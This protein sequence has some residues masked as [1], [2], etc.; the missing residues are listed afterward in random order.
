MVRRANLLGRGAGRGRRTAVVGRMDRAPLPLARGRIPMPKAERALLGY[1]AAGQPDL[2]IGRSM[3][4]PRPLGSVMN[5]AKFGGPIVRQVRSGGRHGHRRQPGRQQDHPGLQSAM[6]DMD[7]TMIGQECIDELADYVGL[8]PHIAAITERAMRGEIAFEPALR[9][10][11]ALLK[12]L[13]PALIERNHQEPHHADA[14]RPRPWSPPCAS[15]APGPAWCR[16]ASRCSSM[17]IAA[18]IG[19]DEVARAIVLK[20]DPDGHL[21]GAGD[22]ADLRP[23]PQSAPR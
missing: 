23:R 17:Q 15:T 1:T 5:A 3:D 21:N 10:R 14:G 11:V 4:R 13:P 8:K 20:L 18:M 6:A 12:G 7:S 2:E 22:R 9:E 16:A 19:F